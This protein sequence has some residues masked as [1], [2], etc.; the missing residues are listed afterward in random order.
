MT[1][2]TPFEPAR[3]A[4][5]RS[6]NSYEQLHGVRLATL[7]ESPP[8]HT[9]RSGNTTPPRTSYASTDVSSATP[10]LPPTTFQDD[11]SRQSILGHERPTAAHM[12]PQQGP[13]RHH[14]GT[15]YER[16]RNR[17]NESEPAACVTTSDEVAYQEFVD[18]WVHSP[19]EDLTG[20]NEFTRHGT[21][22]KGFVN[23]GIDETRFS[24]SNM[25]SVYEFLLPSPTSS[26]YRQTNTQNLRDHV[27]ASELSYSNYSNNGIPKNLRNR[28]W[29]PRVRFRGA[30]YVE[31]SDQGTDDRSYRSES[32]EIGMCP[33]FKPFNF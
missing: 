13:P 19:F 25:G 3:D 17:W 33:A 14:I 21:E 23:R 32:E 28:D 2:L 27:E 30:S 15:I 20:R 12:P 18:R 1:Q 16:R 8:T 10:I 24:P 7:A 9:T 5:D 6:G 29:Q 26:V 22:R 11:Y 31:P 4:V